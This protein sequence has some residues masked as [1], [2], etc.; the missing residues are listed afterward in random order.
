[1]AGRPNKRTRTMRPLSFAPFALAGFLALAAAPALAE[2]AVSY[3]DVVRAQGQVARIADPSLRAQAETEL[4]L[5]E[6]ALSDAN[7]SHAYARI[8][9][10]LAYAG[11]VGASRSVAAAPAP[12]GAGPRVAQT[13]PHHTL[14]D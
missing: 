6:S 14:R 9:R 12:A 11:A 8:Q 7:G 1:M 3:A 13:P 2:T 4:H 5:A 10:A